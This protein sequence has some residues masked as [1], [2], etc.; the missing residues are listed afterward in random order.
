MTALALYLA[1]LPA[2]LLLGLALR[3]GALQGLALFLAW[4]LAL[5]AVA[6]C[7]PWCHRSGRYPRWLTTPD[8]D[9]DRLRLQPTLRPPHFGAYEASVRTVY[10]RA[11]R[12]LGDIYWLGLRNQL[13]GL[14]Y[15]LKPARYKGLTSYA[16]LPRALWKHGWGLRFVADGLTLY[17]LELG[18][19]VLLAGWA[20]RGVVLDPNS[21]RAAVNMEFR[22]M[23]SVRKA[24]N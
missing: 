23:F 21:P 22:P 1:A 12:L 20:V 7:A 2:L 3:S 10:A 16:H 15:A 13:F 5:G 24:G 14:R 18:P 19:L 6:A 17:K 8:D 9:Y 4:P 11:G